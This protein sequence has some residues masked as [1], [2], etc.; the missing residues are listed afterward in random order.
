M[1]SKICTRCFKELDISTFTST[2]KNYEITKICQPCREYNKTYL[3]QYREQKQK[4]YPP[5]DLEKAKQYFADYYKANN[6]Y[7]KA[8]NK[9]RYL[10][11]KERIKEAESTTQS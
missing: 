7:L 8:K 9:S 5:K 3:K 6:E 2:R 11:N 10:R 1:A 4:R